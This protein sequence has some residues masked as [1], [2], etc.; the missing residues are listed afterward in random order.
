[1]PTV[2]LIDG[3]TIAF[4]AVDPNTGAAVSGVTVSNG[5]VYVVV[6]DAGGVQ[7]GALGPFMYAPGQG[8]VAV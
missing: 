6:E 5:V 7:A 1:M 3:C 8:G 4:E 2:D